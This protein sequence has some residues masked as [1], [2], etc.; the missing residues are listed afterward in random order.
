MD[1]VITPSLQ[2]CHWNSNIRSPFSVAKFCIVEWFTQYFVSQGFV[3]AINAM[4]WYYEQFEQDYKQ[5]VQMWERADLLESP[6]AALNLAVVHS[7][8]LYP[9]KA[10]DQVSLNTNCCLWQS[11]STAIL[12]HL[13]INGLSSQQF[14]AYQYYLKSAERG[15]I[16][17]AV[18][19]ADIWTTGIPGRVNR[20]PE[21]AV[22][23]ATSLH[24]YFPLYVWFS[25]CLDWHVSLIDYRWVKWA[26]EHNGYL[27]SIL[28]K[29][30]NSY[31]KSDM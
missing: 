11:N 13:V 22:L 21:D 27:G 20:R 15:L 12:E 10:A 7:Q 29:A 2:I 30:L 5:A 16:R 26:A 9:G 25:S 28:R 1:Q 14:T 19:L 31:L 23:L 24:I 18:H 6:D 4:A 3:P 17:G 8:G